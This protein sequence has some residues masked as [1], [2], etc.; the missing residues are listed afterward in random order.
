M[1]VLS[2]PLATETMPDDCPEN[3]GNCDHRQIMIEC[4]R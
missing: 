2:I 3:S 4:K 1:N